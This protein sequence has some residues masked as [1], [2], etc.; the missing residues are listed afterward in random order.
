[1]VSRINKIRIFVLERLKWEQGLPL[2]YEKALI[3]EFWITSGDEFAVSEVEKK[4]GK[5]GK[6][7]FL[8]QFLKEFEM[9]KK[10]KKW[11]DEWQRLPY[12]TR[13]Y[14][15]HSQSR[16]RTPSYT[17]GPSSY[18]TPD[19]YGPQPYSCSDW[20]QLGGL[21]DYYEPPHECSN[22]S[23][24]SVRRNACRPSGELSDYYE[25]PHVRSNSSWY[26]ARQ[27]VYRPPR[28]AF[29][30]WDQFAEQ[31]RPLRQPH[32]AAKARTWVGLRQNRT[33]SRFCMRKMRRAGIC[34]PK[35]DEERCL[36]EVVTHTHSPKLD[37]CLD[38]YV[39]G[40]VHELRDQVE[41]DSSSSRLVVP[42]G[43]TCENT[44]DL[45][46]YSNRRLVEEEHCEY[47]GNMLL[48]D[49]KSETKVEEVCGVDASNS[50]ATGVSISSI[51][52]L[53][54][55]HGVE[56]DRANAMHLR[57]KTDESDKW[58]VA[59]L[60]EVLNLCVGK[61]AE[62]ESMLYLGEYMG[63]RPS[64]KRAFLEHP[65]IFYVSMRHERKGRD[66]ERRDAGSMGRRNNG[67]GTEENVS[68]RST[69]R[70]NG[71]GGDYD[72]RNV[73][74]RGRH[75]MNGRDFERRNTR[76]GLQGTQ[77]PLEIGLDL[78]QSGD[79]HS[80]SSSCLTEQT[81]DVSA[82]HGVARRLELEN[83][84]LSETVEDGNKVAAVKKGFEDLVAKVE[85]Y[86]NT[87]N[88]A[89]DGVLQTIIKHSS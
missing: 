27:N 8:L 55:N 82:I 39:C 18:F 48:M 75:E 77:I 59:V 3:P 37:E 45:D 80:G 29:N 83:K 1:M 11:L 23:R 41:D 63:M 6:I 16:P 28:N 50:N 17:A 64:F 49:S 87:M 42:I 88:W 15:P 70:T 9:D 34:P 78:K 25:P 69:R 74:N 24:Y 40:Y 61:K 14:P 31:E 66:F 56:E 4:R 71:R 81:Q 58:V 53:D 72:E 84:S 35:Q 10:Y 62:K 86:S 85:T 68:R 73:T 2:D 44:R 79:P 19:M 12:R 54:E 32:C 5:V 67:R 26:S 52:L 30:S 7:E 36:G 33:S 57:T 76:E 13:R 89:K 46:Y 21:S 43:Y 60:H 20:E 47:L 38:I 51:A 65:G 22:S